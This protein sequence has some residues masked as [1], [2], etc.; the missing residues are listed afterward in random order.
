MKTTLSLR[1]TEDER[2]LLDLLADQE[3]TSMQVEAHNALAHRLIKFC[4]RFRKEI[5]ESPAETPDDAEND[6]TILEFLAGAEA[7]LRATLADDS[8]TKEALA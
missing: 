2:I 8:L 7:D 3:D 5:E 6:K 1:M 4:Q